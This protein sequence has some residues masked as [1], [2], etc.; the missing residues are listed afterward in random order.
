MDTTIAAA[1][2]LSLLLSGVKEGKKTVH[3][4][5][6]ETIFSHGDRSDAVFYVEVG[7][8]KLSITSKQGKEAV[9]GLVDGGSLFGENALGSSPLRAY[10]AVALT[11]VRALKIQREVAL[12]LISKRE[13]VCRAFLSSMVALADRVREELAD[14]ILYQSEQR[15]ARAL[16]TLSELNLTAMPNNAVNVN[17]QM[18]ANMIGTTRQRVNILLQ[19]FKRLGLIDDTPKLRVHRGLRDT[20]GEE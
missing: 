13:D 17:Q 3:F 10:G 8:V 11:K 16:L 2:D 5:R 12:H 1:T 6:N 19:Q 18:L 9:I 4:R 14:N 20:A 7:A 15:L